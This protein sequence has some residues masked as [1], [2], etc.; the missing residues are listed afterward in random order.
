MLNQ[1]A[2]CIRM[3]AKEV[4]GQLKGKNTMIKKPCGEVKVAEAV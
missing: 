3:I 1:M 4:F 2:D